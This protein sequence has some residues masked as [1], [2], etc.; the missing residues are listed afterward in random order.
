MTRHLRHRFAWF[1]GLCRKCGKSRKKAGAFC[2]PKK[3]DW[4]KSSLDFKGPGGYN[5]LP[6]RIFPLEGDKKCSI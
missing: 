1:F 5:P 3:F 2:V 4:D 6:F